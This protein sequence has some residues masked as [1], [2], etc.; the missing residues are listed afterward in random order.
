MVHNV[1]PIVTAYTQS[2]NTPHSMANINYRATKLPQSAQT[3]EGM[4][5]LQV[6]PLVW[7]GA[8]SATTV[9]KRD[10]LDGVAGPSLA[11]V[12]QGR[13]RQ[14]GKWQACS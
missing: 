7:L 3:V 4:V 10:I 8:N 9:T 13:G 14:R 11:R 2:R 6:I 12:V 1:P 5:T